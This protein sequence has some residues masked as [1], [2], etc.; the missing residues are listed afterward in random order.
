MKKLFLL[1]ALVAMFASGCEKDSDDG[2]TGNSTEQPDDGGNGDNGDNGD[3]GGSNDDDDNKEDGND[4]EVGLEV[5]PQPKANEI[6]YTTT[7][8][9]ILDLGNKQFYSSVSSHTIK[10]KGKQIFVLTFIQDVS[11]IATAFKIEFEDAER[12]Q[13]IRLPEGMTTIEESAFCGCKG[14]VG[15]TLP[16]SV[17]E[18]KSSAFEGCYSLAKINYPK[19]LQL[20]VIRHLEVAVN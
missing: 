17:T 10:D 7:D 8:G 9:V 5:L 13:S 3:N 16:E 4:D 11:K 1:L 19:V 20:S 14:L 12:L 18:L 15:I 6:Y 2:G